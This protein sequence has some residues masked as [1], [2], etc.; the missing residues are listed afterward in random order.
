MTTE[1]D[2]PQKGFAGL[3]S[4][5]SVVE[6]PEP[7]KKAVEPKKEEATTSVR[8]APLDFSIQPT[9]PEVPIWKKLW[10]KWTFGVFVLVVI[11]A[12]FN[13]QKDS[14]PSYS[15]SG[16]S[17]STT[18]L[19][20]PMEE[21]PPV[22]TGMTLTKDQIRYCLSEKIRLEAWETAVNNYSDLS[23]NSFNNSVDSYNSRCASYRYKKYSL[24]SVT[25]EVEARRSELHA[26]GLGRAALYSGK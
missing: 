21:M 4:M 14:Q 20:P 15:S 24:D 1:S 11:L 9:A 17:S 6:V 18:T 7:E 8:G 22:G 10:A 25:S 16:N 12:A 19:M 5:V 26:E 13:N 2:K 23:V 3:N